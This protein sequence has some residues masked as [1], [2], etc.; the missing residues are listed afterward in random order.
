MADVD[1][2][3]SRSPLDRQGLKDQPEAQA[4]RV[5]G[6][7]DLKA[8]QS[9]N[10]NAHNGSAGGDQ[11]ESIQIIALD[12]G[13]KQK[14]VAERQKEVKP[15]P[16]ITTEYLRER[17]KQLPEGP[18]KD[19]YRQLVREQMAELSPEANARAERLAQVNERIKAAGRDEGGVHE[20]MRAEVVAKYSGRVEH[21]QPIE[22]TED[23]WLAA[24]QAI[25]SLPIEKQMEVIGAGLLAGVEQYQHYERERAIGQVIGT[26]QGVGQVAA[27]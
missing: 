19:R 9:L 12:D 26:V 1:E 13:G 22:N 25:A 4:A 2:K 6:A 21:N 27:H 20:V 24:G 14:V 18:E 15:L 7:A 5:A 10:Q 3:R 16:E 11:L 17:A 8:M 23:G